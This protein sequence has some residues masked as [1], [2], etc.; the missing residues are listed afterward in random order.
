MHKCYNHVMLVCL[1]SSAV[2]WHK[3]DDGVWRIMFE[4]DNS[5]TPQQLEGI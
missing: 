2:I 1:Y 4:M 3:D 5:Q